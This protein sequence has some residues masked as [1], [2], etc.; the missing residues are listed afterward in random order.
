MVSDDYSVPTR[1]DY[2]LDRVIAY[3]SEDYLAIFVPMTK[4]LADCHIVSESSSTELL[5]LETM[6]DLAE[7]TTIRSLIAHIP[8]HNERCI[9]LV[10]KIGFKRIGINER[11]ILKGGELQD[12]YIYTRCL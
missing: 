12:Q 1:V 5:S 11:S 10:E 3:V 4:T 7:T 2:E 9:K 8:T 6:H